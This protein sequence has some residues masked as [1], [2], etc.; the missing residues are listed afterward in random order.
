MPRLRS[1][2]VRKLSPQITVDRRSS[3]LRLLPDLTLMGLYRRLNSSRAARDDSFAAELIDRLARCRRAAICSIYGSV[4]RARRLV[5]KV[6]VGAK[7]RGHFHNDSFLVLPCCSLVERLKGTAK[8]RPDS[9]SSSPAPGATRRELNGALQLRKAGEILAYYSRRRPAPRGC[10]RFRIRRTP[11]ARPQ[12][13]SSPSEEGDE[14][15]TT[16]RRICP[17][18]PRGLVRRSPHRLAAFAC[19]GLIAPAQESRRADEAMP[20][21]PSDPRQPLDFRR[22]APLP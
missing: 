2:P 13:E 8:L 10:V 15:R 1:R 12:R 16:R 7:S 14:A 6:Y 18:R 20:Y 3:S 5:A 21:D 22:R 17:T 19:R 9:S 11:S 4:E